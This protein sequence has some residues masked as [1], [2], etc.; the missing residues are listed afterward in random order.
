MRALIILAVLLAA[1]TVVR[2]QSSS[3][4]QRRLRAIYQELIEIDTTQ[5]GGGTTRAA[6]AVAKRLPAAGLAAKEIHIVGPQAKKKNLVTR[7]HG[8][9]A[10]RPLLLL[11]HLD[12]VEAKRSDWSLEPFKL[13]EQDGYFYGRGTLDD[14]AM[15]AIFTEIFLRL[16]EQPA[17][18]DRDVILALT[19]DEEGGPDNGARRTALPASSSTLTMSAPTARTSASASSSSTK[20]SSFCGGS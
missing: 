7:L 20:A 16:H 1:A 11:A 5:S 19:A 6:E 12:V 15:A 17:Q 14:K 3:P 18:L 13:V 2:A 8:S 10:R 9:G 4:Q